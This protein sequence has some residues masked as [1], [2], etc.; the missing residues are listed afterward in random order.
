MKRYIKTFTPIRLSAFIMMSCI[1]SIWSCIAITL[2]PDYHNYIGTN[3]TLPLS[4]LG[5][6]LL[7][8]LTDLTA[9]VGRE[10]PLF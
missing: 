6:T 7:T 8:L 1:F 4:I 3:H 5:G 2:I 9:G 10:S